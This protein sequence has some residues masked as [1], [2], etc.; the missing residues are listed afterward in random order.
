LHPSLASLTEA[1][2]DGHE[3]DWSSIDLSS[4][5]GPER[6][7]VA[8]LR[9]IAEIGRCLATLTTDSVPSWQ[10]ASRGSAEVPM[11]TVWGTLEIRE[12]VG[13]GRFGDVYRAWDPA[14]DR[15][16][17]L[18]LLRR[19]AVQASA[20][21]V[22]VH[23][24][25]LMGRVR[26]PN[27]ATI[28]G[29]ATQ[30]GRTGLWMEF[31]D[32]RTLEAELRD[33]GTL[34][35]TEVARIGI[36]L[37]RALSAVHGAGLLHRDVKA[38]NVMRDAT[39]RV[40]IGDF[41]T[42]LELD[43]ENAEVTL[44]GTPV[45]LAPEVLRGQPATPRSDIY[46]LGVLL[47][48]L[49]T[50]SYPVKGRSVGEIKRAHLNGV[51]SRLTDLRPDVPIAFAEAVERAIAVDPAARVETAAELEQL[52]ERSSLA[53]REDR[54]RRGTR[55][56][57][58]RLT[59]IA[60]A[61]AITAAVA[62]PSSRALIMAVGLLAAACLSA[63]TGWLWYRSADTRIPFAA[64]DW[65]LI[66]RF[67]NRTGEAAF[68]DVLEQALQRELINS[69]FVNVVPRPRIEDVLT[70]M[71]KPADS[72]VDGQLAREVA[73]RDGAIRALLTG[74]LDRV[75]A[76]YVLTTNIVDPGDGRILTNVTSDVS[77]PSELLH[78]VRQQ[79]LRVRRV[80][81][82]ALPAIEQ[83]RRALEKVTTPSLPALQLYSRAAALLEGEYW[84]ADPEAMSRFPE[85][86]SRYSSA[87]ALL[88][89]ATEADPSFAAA[90]MLLGHVIANQNRPPR[91]YR[92]FVEKAF[93]LAGNL[94]PV[95][96]WMI[97]GFA[98]R[99]RPWQ[100]DYR[101][102]DAAIRAY[103]ATLQIVPD[104]Y[105]ALL[106]LQFLYAM[107]GR[108]DDQER[109]TLHAARLRPH[110]FRFAIDTARIR[111]GHGD[112]DV[113]RSIIQQHAPETANGSPQLGA[114]PPET[115][116]WYRL[117][118]AHLAWLDGDVRRALEVVRAVEGSWTSNHSLG[119]FQLANAYSGLGRYG[120]AERVVRRMA[121]AQTDFHLALIATRRERWDELRMLL[122]PERREFQVLRSRVLM[123]VRAGWLDDAAWVLEERRRRAQQ[124]TP[125]D[126]DEVEGQLRV[127]QGKYVEGLAQLE[128]LTNGKAGTRFGADISYAIARRGVGD[129]S[130]AIR[131]LER[132][133]ERKSHAVA[134]DAWYV[135]GWLDSRVLLA[136]YYVE[137]G[138][139][140]DATRVADETRR[141]LAVAD[142]DHP[143]L[144]RLGR[145]LGTRH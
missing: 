74:G 87:E 50:G 28:Y 80:L 109:V 82:E 106:E 88:R 44:A 33:R 126:Q 57:R 49:A 101:E 8:E 7:R 127:A 121:P 108:V 140:A 58:I 72:P 42:G 39:G 65:V 66:A 10:S 54:N 77:V 144:L 64:R 112:R 19:D 93:A 115:L 141:L 32:G 53:I 27:V 3:I 94:S 46:S 129:L 75:G 35:A 84:R 18:K 123:L 36:E 59:G 26:H 68:D 12:H 143:L 91:E 37:C 22:V 85:S 89:G 132:V 41:G 99:Y 69:G 20:G 139:T 138:R 134:H 6:D 107:L 9:A 48:H 104:H 81:G 38:Q 142:P 113:A 24:G 25:R 124:P 23:E 96:R 135:A 92:P 137:A 31:I 21:S 5:D 29:A 43:D 119:L 61:T 70:L 111:L 86:P 122:H 120:D 128:H 76:T 110:S 79:A 145:L 90:W 30:A 105:W 56:R 60:L 133:G 125:N 136:E 83:S 15:H 62:V 14:L 4:L 117:W 1:V 40:V 114:L 98:W 2:A 11:P 118:D 13:R 34:E 17:A 130:D 78:Q 131:Y 97:E 103:E 52:F 73:L 63:A 45:Y 71:R 116:A 102:V 95:E 100:G 67:A 47:F 16:V 51:R 55:L